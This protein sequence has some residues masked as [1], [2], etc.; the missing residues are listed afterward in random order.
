MVWNVPQWGSRE[1]TLLD[2]ATD[3]LSAGKTSR[4]YKKLVYEDQTASS[5]YAYIKPME[6]AGNIYM[7][8]LV[9]PGKTVEEVEKTMNDVLQEFLDKGPTQEELDRVRSNYFSNFLK[10][11]ERIGGFGGKSDILATN[12]VYGGSPDFYKTTLKYVAEATIEDIQKACQHW[13]G[14]GKYVLVCKPFPTLQATGTGVDRSKMPELGTPVPSSFPDLQKATLKNGLKVILAQR[15]GVPTVVGRLVMNAGFASDAL[16]K[17]GLA[18]LAMDM[19][20]EGTAT[21]DALQI[22]EKMQLL[23][24]SINA[25]SDLDAS[26]VNFTT[27]L[28]T[29]DPTLDLFTDILLN[30]AFPQKEFDRLKKDHLNNIEREKSEPFGMALRVIP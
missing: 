26:Y 17:P 7:E 6:I 28:P 9:K 30:P 24:A 23:G 29:F 20:D 2:L 12:Q 14:S 1:A 8:A 27:L 25:G 5:A 11:I 16:A 10:G 19:L 13:L 21:L 4:L 15:K 18:S 3:V 22:S